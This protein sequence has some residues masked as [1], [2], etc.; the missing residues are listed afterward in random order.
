ML[1]PEKVGTAKVVAAIMGIN[2]EVAGN[3]DQTIGIGRLEALVG[4]RT[5]TVDGNK[6]E[7]CVG[8]VVLSKGDVS[9]KVS[10]AKTCMVGGAIV[11]LIKGGHTIEASGPATFIGALHKVE[12]KTKITFKVGGSEVVIEGGGVTFKAPIIAVMSPK[13]QLTKAVSQGPV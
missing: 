4:D 8:L 5:E 13:I 11:D 6:D 7:Q 2:T 9:E 1:G 10:G 12:A 3:M